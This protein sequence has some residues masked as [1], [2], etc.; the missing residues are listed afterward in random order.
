MEN[1]NKDTN[2]KTTLE[3]ANELQTQT[4]TQNKV[5]KKV[6]KKPAAK[7]VISSSTVIL[8]KIFSAK[9][10]AFNFGELEISSDVKKHLEAFSKEDL[11]V[12]IE[13]ALKSIKIEDVAKAYL[14]KKQK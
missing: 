12:V 4:Q 7:K 6:R 9:K 2:E 3:N 11:V 8:N 5:V 1:F 14:E 13:E 10:E